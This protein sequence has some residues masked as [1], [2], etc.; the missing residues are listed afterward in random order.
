MVLVMD[1][2]TQVI[3]KPDG[4]ECPAMPSFAKVLEIAFPPCISE[5]VN[6]ARLTHRYDWRVEMAIKAISEA[7]QM[8]VTARV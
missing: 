3:V 5:R 6:A 7:E 4:Y 1:D 2:G 8:D